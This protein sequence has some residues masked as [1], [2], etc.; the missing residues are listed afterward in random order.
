MSNEP[1]LPVP[2]PLAADDL[3]SQVRQTVQ[4]N[5][6]QTMVQSY[7]QVGQLI[8]Q[9]EQVGRSRAIYGAKTLQLFAQ[10]LAQEFGKGFSA[11]NLRNF[12]QLYQTFTLDDIRYTPCSELSCSHLR[13]LM[14][15]ADAKARQWYAAEAVHETWKPSWPVTGPSSKTARKTSND[16]FSISYK[17][18]AESA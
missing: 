18:I 1:L 17:K 4:Y 2:H 3:W 9:D 10:R 11:A 5:V 16:S 8:V 13:R 7:W 15:V 14:R 12:R 6:N